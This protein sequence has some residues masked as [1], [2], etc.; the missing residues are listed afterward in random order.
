MRVLLRLPAA[1][2][3][4]QIEELA[5]DSTV[6]VREEHVAGGLRPQQAGSSQA[7]REPA[8]LPHRS[9]TRTAGGFRPRR[10]HHRWTRPGTRVCPAGRTGTARSGFRKSGEATTVTWFPHWSDLDGPGCDTRQE[11]LLGDSA[12]EPVMHPERICRGGGRTLV[13]VLRRRL[14]HQPLRPPHRMTWCH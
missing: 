5:D 11:V 14:D 9:N 13:V 8:D 4:V 3:N 7:E 6:Q 2:L 1:P 12:I 10:D